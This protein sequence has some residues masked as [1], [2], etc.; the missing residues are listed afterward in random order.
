MLT[1]S[2]LIVAAVEYMKQ[3]DSDRLWVESDFEAA[4][5][6]GIY[7][8]EAELDNMVDQY[9]ANHKRD[10]L[11]GRYKTL[12]VALK[13]FASN[14]MTKWAEAKVRAD[15]VATK[16]E[17]LLGPKDERDNVSMK[18]VPPFLLAD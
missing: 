12:P 17:A 5:G 3:H 15:V 16:F 4:S 7:V 11:E 14:P 13:F 18:K 9:I 6:I 1:C 10:V 2:L 8:S